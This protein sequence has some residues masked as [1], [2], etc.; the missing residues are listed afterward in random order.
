MMC[1][2]ITKVRLLTDNGWCGTAPGCFGLG[3]RESFTEEVAFS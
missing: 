2:Q 1:T 3:V